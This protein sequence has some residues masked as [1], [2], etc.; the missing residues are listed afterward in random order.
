MPSQWTNRRAAFRWYH[1]ITLSAMPDK[2]SLPTDSPTSNANNE[3]GENHETLAPS[4]VGKWWLHVSISYHSLMD[5][6][7]ACPQY[8]QVFISDQRKFDPKTCQK[9][10]GKGTLG[11]VNYDIFR[12]SFSGTLPTKTYRLTRTDLIH[13][14]Q[15]FLKWMIRISWTKYLIHCVPYHT[16]REGVSGLTTRKYKSIVSIIRAFFSGLSS[17][18]WFLKFF[19]RV[20]V[21]V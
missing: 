1:R 11:F 14:N 12:A 9:S 16:T 20:R 13:K 6:E 5:F 10:H 19:D 3:H 21:I 18:P 7:P 17:K 15:L 4:F 8:S 2:Y